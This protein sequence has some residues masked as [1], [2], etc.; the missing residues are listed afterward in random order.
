MV[1]PG[2]FPT[3]LKVEKFTYATESNSDEAA[4]RGGITFRRYNYV[5]HLVSGQVV[6]IQLGL[7]LLSQLG[8]GPGHIFSDYIPVF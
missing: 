6:E 3:R 8:L 7:R 2:L 5:Q 1:F 4:G